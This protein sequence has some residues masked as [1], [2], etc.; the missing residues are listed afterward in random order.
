M[1]QV[2]PDS[3]ILLATEP[4]SFRYGIDGMCAWCRNKLLYDPKS[5]S[6]FGFINRNRT[7]VRVLFYD[8]T[9]FWVMTKRLSTGKFP[10]WPKSEN[11][12][13]PANAKELMTILWGNSPGELPIKKLK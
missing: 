2:T 6:I 3:H 1:I 7:M 8:G 10:W 12:V 9:G 13:N 4:V 5:G 11:D